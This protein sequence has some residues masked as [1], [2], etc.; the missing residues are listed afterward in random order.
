MTLSPDPG[1]ENFLD[2]IKYSFFPDFSWSSMTAH[3]CY[4]VKI[5]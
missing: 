3:I 4:L 5:A 2:M 1:K